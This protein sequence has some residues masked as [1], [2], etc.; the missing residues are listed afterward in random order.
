MNHSELTQLDNQ[1]IWH[2]YTQMQTAP[3]AIPIIKAKGALLFD[4]LGNTYIDAVSSWWTNI[5]GHCHP[6][7][8]KQINEQ[9]KTL[10]HVIFAGFTHPNA[11]YLAQ[12]LLQL[13]PNNQQKVFFSDNGSTAVEVA[14]KMAI[15]YWQNKEQGQRK[16]ILAFENAYH[17]DTFGAMS[18]SARS[19]F[20]Q[21]FS[22]YLFD[23]I[24]IPT[25]YFGYEEN[26]LQTF[27]Q[28]IEKYK[29]KIACFIFEPLVQGAGGM[30]M[31]SANALQQLLE[32][33]QQNQ[34][35]SIADE[36][37]TG[38]GRTGKLFAC[39]YLTQN[40]D[41]F[42]LSK[43]LTGGLLP[44]GITTCNNMIYN[45]FLSSNKQHTFFHGHSFTANPI[46]CKAALASL[47][48]LQ[49]PNCKANIARINKQ[50]LLIQ[51]KW[52][53]HKAVNKVNV[54]GTILA[55]ELKTNTKT[56]YFNTLK[57]QIYEMALQHKVLLRPLGNIIYVL[58]PYCISN[59][60]LTIVYNTISYILNHIKL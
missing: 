21:A 44:L 60:Q 22:N 38:F 27:K 5:H 12:Q 29:N 24:S 7:L 11:V 18:V 58:P 57:Q 2:P 1:F 19:A 53:Y 45:A 39:N 10:D 28:Y 13:L 3:Y 6:Y 37:M 4:D 23:V 59:K 14:L 42:C 16:I 51:K 33:C 8:S 9:L 40:P 32:I 41:I 35:I 15:Q 43:A 17:G 34:I 25:P 26:S 46:A 54:C 31:Y 36:V 56:S 52:Q 55:I 20:T 48:L 47:F 30:L 49:Q 50:H